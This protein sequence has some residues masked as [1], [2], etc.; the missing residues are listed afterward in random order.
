VVCTLDSRAAQEGTASLD[1]P[2]LR[3][4]WD[5]RLTVH[6]EIT[7]ETYEWGRHNY[8]RLAPWHNVAHI[9]RVERPTA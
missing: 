9:F 6:D 2:A 4:D 1:M 3:A 7:G 8:V 5:D